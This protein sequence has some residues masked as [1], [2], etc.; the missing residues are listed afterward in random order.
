MRMSINNSTGVMLQIDQINV[1][2]NHND[3]H[4]TG[5]DKTLRLR[6][7]SLGSAIWSGDIYASSYNLNVSPYLPNGT[8]TIIF[9]FHQ[10]YDNLDG[11]ERIVI[12]FLT[13]GCQSY[14]IDSMN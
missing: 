10:T 3:G 6:Q 11:T 12:T 9:T 1:T 7:A 8:S 2:W 13:N 14:V 4:Q 5:G